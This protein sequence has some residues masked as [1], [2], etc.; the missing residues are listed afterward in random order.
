[1]AAPVPPSP[2]APLELPPLDE[3]LA[4]EEEPVPDDEPPDEE[5][6]GDEGPHPG[7]TITFSSAGDEHAPNTMGSAKAAIPTRFSFFTGGK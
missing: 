5:G 2:V 1:M 7:T 6:P 4:P 3:L